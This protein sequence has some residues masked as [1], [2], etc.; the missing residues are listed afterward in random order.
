LRRLWC[1]DAAAVNAAKVAGGRQRAN[2]RGLFPNTPA[3]P[4]VGAYYTPYST[5]EA[6]AMQAI[7]R[8]TGKAGVTVEDV[9]RSNGTHHFADIV[10]THRDIWAPL[11]QNVSGGATPSWYQHKPAVGFY[12]LYTRRNTSEP[13]VRRD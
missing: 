13:Q 5:I 9:L 3:P 4:R 1:T 2:T 10:D 6:L 11:F 12:C 7:E 8:A